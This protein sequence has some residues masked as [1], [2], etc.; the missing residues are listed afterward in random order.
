MRFTRLALGVPGLGHRLEVF[1]ETGDPGDDP[2]PIGLQ[3]GLAGATGKDAEPLLAEFFAPA[4]QPGEQVLEQRHLYLCHPF[5]GGCVLGED[6]ENHRL[7]VD[8]VAVEG[9][10]QVPLLCWGEAVVEDDNVDVEPLGDGRQLV[11]LS[12]ADE[13]RR[14]GGVAL[15]QNHVDRVGARCLGEP[16]QL[17]ERSFG[18]LGIGAPK[19]DADQESALADYLDVGDGRGETAA[20]AGI[21]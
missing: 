13:R 9:T 1:P 8:H 17:F 3:L 19:C 2:P 16:R 12:L 7:A 14:V 4:A 18:L 10:L 5:P 20:L 11:D 6:V 21:A 15:H